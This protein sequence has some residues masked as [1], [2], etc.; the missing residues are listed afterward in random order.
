MTKKPQQDV[1][2]TVQIT[3]EIITDKD[4]PL[5]EWLRQLSVLLADERVCVDFDA[6]PYGTWDSIEN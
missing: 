5:I 6:Q 4:S 2:G 3:L 1:F